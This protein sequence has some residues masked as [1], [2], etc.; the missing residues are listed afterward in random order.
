[1]EI[2]FGSL[3]AVVEHCLECLEVCWLTMGPLVDGG[4]V[5]DTEPLPKLKGKAPPILRTCLGDFISGPS[6]LSFSRP[7]HSGGGPLFVCLGVG[8][9]LSS[10]EPD[11][12]QE[13]KPNSKG[14]AHLPSSLSVLNSNPILVAKHA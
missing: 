13:L 10:R 4:L 6:G 5:K 11:F 12:T 8:D 2:A 9:G 7:K 14:R 3:K 1:M